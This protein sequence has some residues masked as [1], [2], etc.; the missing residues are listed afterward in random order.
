LTL[1]EISENV[2]LPQ[3][4]V[5]EKGGARLK[6]TFRITLH[7]HEK[8]HRQKLVID[9]SQ[10]EMQ[11]HVALKL[12]GFLLFYQYQPRIEEGIGWHYK[13]DLVGLNQNGELVLWIDCGN[14]EMKKIDKIA[15]KVG[16]S[17]KFVI[18][19]RTRNEM[20]RLAKQVKTRIKHH[21]RV[22]WIAFDDQVVDNLAECFDVTNDLNCLLE[23]EH[24]SLTIENRNG[25]RTLHS[26]VLSA[27]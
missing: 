20:Q 13:P 26:A 4:L 21:R 18:L 22:E 11:W 23:A 25:N 3:A 10:G 24:L 5:F 9:A 12:L 7:A 14:I 19:K 15:T 2:Q 1:L 8:T 6:F 17:A 27:P 16:T